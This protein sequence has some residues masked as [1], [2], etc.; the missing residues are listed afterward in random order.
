MDDVYYT[1]LNASTDLQDYSDVHSEVM[2]ASL[3][4][5]LLSPT[6]KNHRSDPKGEARE[7][8]CLQTHQQAVYILWASHQ[9]SECSQLFRQG[10]QNL[11]FIIDGVYGTNTDSVIILP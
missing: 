3:K 1:V 2:P 9:T 10:Q 7:L 5:T 8:P 6:G 4:S 11:I